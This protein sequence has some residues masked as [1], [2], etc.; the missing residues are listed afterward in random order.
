MAYAEC[1]VC[2]ESDPTKRLQP[3]G[4]EAAAPC[5]R[6]CSPVCQV[7][8]KS[9]GVLM[10]RGWHVKHIA[11]PAGLV[12]LGPRLLLAL[13]P[14]VMWWVL[15]M[16]LRPRDR[17]IKLPLRGG[18]VLSF[19]TGAAVREAAGRWDENE[20]PPPAEVTNPAL[21]AFEPATGLRRD[22][23]GK[24]A[25][26]KA[27]GAHA[28]TPMQGWDAP[29]A[30]ALTRI[31]RAPP[32]LPAPPPADARRAGHREEE[33]GAFESSN[34]PPH[35]T[36]V[37]P[38]VTWA[39]AVAPPHLNT[40]GALQGGCSA[41][42]VD[43]LGSAA[44]AVGD[45][46]SCGVATSLEVQYVSAARRGEVLEWSATILKRGKRLVIAEVRATAPARGGAARRLVVV[47][48]VTKSMRGAPAK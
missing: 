15:S 26:F 16:V 1:K 11:P 36:P 46:H 48:T 9:D 19:G 40:F 44:V 5:A 27:F 45:E 25:Y 29:L 24:L 12:G 38:A 10:A 47:G 42:L 14:D 3:R 37:E 28:A 6:A 34:V 8:R 22:E 33:C 43:V 31:E 41:S 4:L 32:P 35:S 20:A 7:Y 2:C 23:E 30:S 21:S 13:R 18:E 17:E 39:L